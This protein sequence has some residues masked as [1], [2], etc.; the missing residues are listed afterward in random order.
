MIGKIVQVLT[1]PL[2]QPSP[3]LVCFS[4]PWDNPHVSG[5]TVDSTGI[6]RLY[7]QNMN[8]LSSANGN[9]EALV[10]AILQDGSRRNLDFDPFMVNKFLP[11]TKGSTH[12]EK[13]QTDVQ[14]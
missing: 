12:V 11:I 6:F 4:F 9:L 1:L 7:S 10:R 13:Q 8:G 5:H 14:P 3:P 2:F